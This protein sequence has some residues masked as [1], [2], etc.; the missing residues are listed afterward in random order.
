MI[1]MYLSRYLFTRPW[2]RIMNKWPRAKLM[3][4]AIEKNE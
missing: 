2:S 3:F 1:V 4:R